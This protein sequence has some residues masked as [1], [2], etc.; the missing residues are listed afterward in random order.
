MFLYWRKID[1]LRSFGYMA[2]QA[3][4]VVIDGHGGRA[5][6][7]YVAEN[8]GKNIVKAI[9]HVGGKDDELEQAIRGGYL[10]TD[11]EFLNQ[12]G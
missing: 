4:F 11:Q 6:T 12:V 7:D 8:L 2:Y 5:A 10:L 9:E 3:F 1:D